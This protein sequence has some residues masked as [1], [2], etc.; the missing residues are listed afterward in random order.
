[1]LATH[2][3]G[4]GEELAVHTAAS[5]RGLEHAALWLVDRA[6][7]G[8]PQVAAA[9]RGP[10]RPSPSPSRKANETRCSPSASSS[11]SFRLAPRRPGPP[12]ATRRLRPGAPGGGA[13]RASENPMFVAQVLGYRDWSMLVKTYGRWIPEVNRQTGTLVEAQCSSEWSATVNRLCLSGG[14][15]HGTPSG[16]RSA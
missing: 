12:A 11:Q 16:A 7:G 13:R 3:G 4:V 5:E 15:P 9:G 10:W 6:L 14:A 2:R 8:E 1:M